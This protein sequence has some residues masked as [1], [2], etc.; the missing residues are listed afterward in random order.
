MVHFERSFPCT[1]PGKSKEDGQWVS[2]SSTAMVAF[3]CSLGGCLVFDPGWA[4]QLH[5]QQRSS[6]CSLRRAAL[7]AGVGTC[8]RGFA[9][10]IFFVFEA[11]RGLFL[12]LAA[13]HAAAFKFVTSAKSA[14]PSGVCA[15]KYGFALVISFAIDG[16][17]YLFLVESAAGFAAFGH[18]CHTCNSCTVC[19]QGGFDLVLA[20]WSAFCGFGCSDA[21]PRT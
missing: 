21:L 2:A 16:C 17:R 13:A 9:S 15:F 3:L 20:F 4:R 8:K 14:P 10:V 1:R 6:S 11:C 18:G 12:E 5:M 7:F 19:V